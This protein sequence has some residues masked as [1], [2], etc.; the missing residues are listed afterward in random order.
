MIL[1]NELR[2][3]YDSEVRIILEDYNLMGNRL[4]KEF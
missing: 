4:T 2:L 1:K 3:Q